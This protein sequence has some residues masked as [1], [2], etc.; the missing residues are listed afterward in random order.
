MTSKRAVIAVSSRSSAGRG[1]RGMA[2]ARRFVGVRNP[3]YRFDT[4]ALGPWII[5]M[6]LSDRER[7]QR[8]V[9]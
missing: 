4:N 9:A 6:R 8:A 3:D 2:A 7:V 5:A 1:E